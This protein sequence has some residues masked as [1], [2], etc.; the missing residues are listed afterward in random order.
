MYYQ[1]S[2]FLLALLVHP[3]VEVSLLLG[4][5]VMFVVGVEKFKNHFDGNWDMNK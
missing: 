2:C 3:L 1:H 5:V 4:L